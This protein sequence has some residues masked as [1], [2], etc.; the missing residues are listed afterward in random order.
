[1]TTALP[2]TTSTPNTFRDWDDFLRNGA[3]GD[4]HTQ[5][6]NWGITTRVILAV[7]TP[8]GDPGYS[9][10]ARMLAC[11]RLT[12]DYRPEA[13][14]DGDPGYVS[15]VEGRETVGISDRGETLGGPAGAGEVP[16]VVALEA[17]DVFSRARLVSLH[18]VGMG[19][20]PRAGV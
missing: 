3:V 13:T 5:T 17:S 16:R 7:P 4:A 8:G 18:D 9:E 11:W 14:E 1:M 6:G 19:G 20:A 12:T 2:L 10:D 15:T